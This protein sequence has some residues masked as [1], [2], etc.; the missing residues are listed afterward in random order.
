VAVKSGEQVHIDAFCPSCEASY[1]RTVRPLVVGRD[2]LTPELFIPIKAGTPPPNAEKPVC[3]TCESP[4][5]F[6]AATSTLAS[7]GRAEVEQPAVESQMDSTA[8]LRVSGGKPVAPVVSRGVDV[9]FAVEP[10]E[11]VVDMKDAGGA[12][13]V[14]TSKRIVRVPYE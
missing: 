1:Y 13:I 6:V 3:P 2:K 7:T 8:T 5:R 12:Y 11:Q 4:L 10:D 9:L 14:V